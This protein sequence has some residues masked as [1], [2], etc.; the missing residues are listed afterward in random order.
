[1]ASQSD[2][3]LVS[4]AVAKVVASGP[5]QFKVQS[6]PKSPALVLCAAWEP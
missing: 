3:Q 1:V 4:S 5:A 6:A 2:P